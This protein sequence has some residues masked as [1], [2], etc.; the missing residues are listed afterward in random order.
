MVP[1]SPTFVNAPA[2]R[3]RPL[4]LGAVRVVCDE[5][6]R[7]VA[8]L[9]VG[10]VR[11][12]VDQFAVFDRQQQIVVSLVAFPVRDRCCML[13]RMRQELRGVSSACVVMVDD[14]SNESKGQRCPPV[15]L[16]VADIQCHGLP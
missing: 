7:I 10:F 8:R 11:S 13:H 12:E 3:A 16:C 14:P 5:Y 9:A 6:L 15:L 4:T 1:T 2:I